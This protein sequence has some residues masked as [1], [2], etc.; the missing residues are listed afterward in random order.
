MAL[1][2]LKG[3]IMPSS[4]RNAAFTLVELAIVLVIIGLIVGGVLAG[5]MLIRNAE[6]NSVVDEK[7]KYEVAV[8][9]FLLKYGALPGDITKP[10]NFWPDTLPGDGDG[11][12][13]TMVTPVWGGAE[14]DAH[15]N[16]NEMW[17][18]WQHLALAG[19]I[20]GQYTGVAGTLNGWHAVAGEN[21][22]KAKI[23]NGA[24]CMGDPRYGW[25]FQRNWTNMITLARIP[26]ADFAGDW[27]CSSG[28]LLPVEALNID[29]KIDDG[30]PGTG[31]VAA[32]TT[33][34]CSDVWTDYWLTETANYNPGSTSPECL[35]SFKIVQ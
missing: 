27:T 16:S 24:W 9:A 28:F 11:Y 13:G 29:K 14:T 26:V 30:K 4:I 31:K 6:L 25:R 21:V 18:F 22:P 8:N 19:F 15:G 2:S 23:P 33:H 3:D 5:Q 17:G 20:K 1:Y 12:I 7:Q 10:G 32:G 35:L 34:G